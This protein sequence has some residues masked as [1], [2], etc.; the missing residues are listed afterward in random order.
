MSRVLC[1][2]ELKAND[3]VNPAARVLAGFC[4]MALINDAELKDALH[5]TIAKQ[6]LDGLDDTHRDAL[7]QKSLIAVV[8]DYGFKNAI[9]KVAAEK[10][11]KVAVGLMETD[12]WSQ[13]VEQAIRDGFDDFLLQLRAAIPKAMKKT[14]HGTEGNYSSCGGVLNCWPKLPE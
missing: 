6:I 3:Q 11:A 7:L 1:C 14:F 2:V 4:F 12:E 10:A 9:E 5:A 8:K 13:R